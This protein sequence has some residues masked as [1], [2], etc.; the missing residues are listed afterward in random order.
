MQIINNYYYRR[1]TEVE[2]LSVT[3]FRRSSTTLMISTG[4]ERFQCT[5]HSRNIDVG[6]AQNTYHACDVSR[7]CTAER[8]RRRRR[9]RRP[10]AE[11]CG[12]VTDNDAN[13]QQNDH[14]F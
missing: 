13:S 9:R 8:P 10:I 14:Y 2:G 6:K 4:L 5:M 7:D 3:Y 12:N 11:L 1:V